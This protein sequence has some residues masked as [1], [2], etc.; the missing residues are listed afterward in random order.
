MPL[1][2][3]F[4]PPYGMAPPGSRKKLL[5]VVLPRALPHAA[6]S[7]VWVTPL[8]RCPYGGYR[9]SGSSFDRVVSVH[10]EEMISHQRAQLAKIGEGPERAAGIYL[11][12]RDAHVAE[13]PSLGR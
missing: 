6:H 1:T 2:C 7:Q 5:C 12:C 13:R 4:E 9:S 8:D 3:D 11:L 10:V